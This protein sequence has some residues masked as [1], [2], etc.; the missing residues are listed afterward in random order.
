MRLALATKPYDVFF[1]AHVPTVN[2]DNSWNESNLQ[3][4]QLAKTH[5]VQ[6]ASL[7]AAGAGAVRD[8]LRARP[9]RVS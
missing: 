4:C 9:G 8:W 6:L 5:W 2:L 7:K 3:G 1:L